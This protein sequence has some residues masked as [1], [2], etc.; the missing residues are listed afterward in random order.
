ERL[1]CLL[2]HSA[3]KFFLSRCNVLRNR[4]QNALPF[5]CGK[6]ASASE[7][8]DSGMN[9]F[10]DVLARGLKNLRDGTPI[11]RPANLNRSSLFNPLAAEIKT[12]GAGRGRR[13]LRHRSPPSRSIIGKRSKE[14]PNHDKMARNEFANH[15]RNGRTSPATKNLAR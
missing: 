7:C 8:P 3:R 14:C 12:L 4:S 1:A 10:F 15:C 13:H 2:R 11:V 9:C 6:T 5:E